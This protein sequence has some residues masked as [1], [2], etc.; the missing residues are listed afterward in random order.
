MYVD[1]Y[2]YLFQRPPTKSDIPQSDG[3]QWVKRNKLDLVGRDREDYL[4]HKSGLLCSFKAQSEY[5]VGD[6][7]Y[8]RYRHRYGIKIKTNVSTVSSHLFKYF[9]IHYRCRP[10]KVKKK[11]VSVSQSNEPMTVPMKTDVCQ[12]SS[13]KEDLD[14]SVDSV[15]IGAQE[16]VAEMSYP[17]VSEGPDLDLLSKPSMEPVNSF[18]LHSEDMCMSNEEL[19]DNIAGIDFVGEFDTPLSH[20]QFTHIQQSQHLPMDSNVHQ[21]TS[22]HSQAP[23]VPMQVHVP[24]A[25]VCTSIL[26]FAPTCGS[27]DGGSKVL[28][29]LSEPL[30]SLSLKSVPHSALRIMFSS[31]DGSSKSVMVKVEVL[32][33]CALR[34]YA[35]PHAPESCVLSLVVLHSENPQCPDAVSVVPVSPRS[36]TFFTFLSAQTPLHAAPMHSI[37]TEPPVPVPT[38]PG[39]R[40]LFPAVGIDGVVPHNT[41][42]TAPAT[43]GM[44]VADPHFQRIQKI[45]LVEKLGNMSNVLRAED[46]LGSEVEGIQSQRQFQHNVNASFSSSSVLQASQDESA[47]AAHDQSKD[48]DNR[49]KDWL[50]DNALSRLSQVEL[51]RLSDQYIFQVVN[52]L[53][54]LADE[55]NELLTELD[56]LDQSGFALLHYCALYNLNTLVPSLLDKGA[57]IHVKSSSPQQLGASALHLA[58][59]AGNL[60]LVVMLISHGANIYGLDGEGC[61]PAD[62]ARFGHY[63][64][65]LTYYN[66]LHADLLAQEHDLL[67]DEQLLIDDRGSTPPSRLYNTSE[68]PSSPQGYL[69]LSGG[70]T[71]ALLT[72]QHH[73]VANG[74]DSSSS[75]LGSGMVGGSNVNSDPSSPTASTANTTTTTLLQNAFSSLTLTDKCALSL[76]LSGGVESS[77]GPGGPMDSPRSK[78]SSVANSRR[79]SCSV[80]FGGDEEETQSLGGGVISDSDF[81][82][83]GVAM[84]LMAPNELQQVEDEV[85]VIQNNVRSWLLRKNY[86]NLRDAAMTLQN[87]WRERKVKIPVKSTWRTPQ[88]RGTGTM[89]EDVKEIETADT[90]ENGDVNGICSEPRPNLKR[91]SDANADSDSA[92]AASTLRLQA[93]TR[94]MLARMSFRTIK[95]QAIA[96]LVI[97]KSI[98]QWWDNRVHINREVLNETNQGEIEKSYQNSCEKKSRPNEDGR[99]A[100]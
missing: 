12:S 5:V 40:Q 2:F 14:V 38:P 66:Q 94:G 16:L 56:A 88:R 4:L 32:T 92:A 90:E 31:S 71:S 46:G 21:T 10:K 52:Q 43:I 79:S 33:S 75:M 81:E 68:L 47:T 57:N 87:A 62:R 24:R 26:D 1:G 45:R 64:E 35:P 85:R 15:C 76:S 3:I 60:P 54:S 84:S 22:I 49:D 80:F 98:V 70:T 41:L 65:L 19:L 23:V 34:I 48:K 59:A 25:L 42:S 97:Q 6:K 100:I 51:E 86:I 9:F 27:C 58:S 36:N 74:M 7:H 39:L 96:S 28:I 37:Y 77:T 8:V 78:P 91:K 11:T 29:C 72:G 61:T 93:L 18:G 17:D 53:V 73:L 63:P 99:Y 95:K 44:G 82:S 83:L 55:S 50:D 20:P 13:A 89:L 30:S 67:M 69:H